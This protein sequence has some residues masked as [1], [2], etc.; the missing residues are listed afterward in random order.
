MN[1]PPRANLFIGYSI[2][3]TGPI[4]TAALNLNYSYQLS[5]KWYST[6]GTS[7]DFGN[8]ILLGSFFSV[9]RIGAD[10]LTS[11]G[12]NL[13][14][15]RNNYTFGLEITPRLSPNIHIGS[16]SAASR[17]DPRYAATQ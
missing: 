16:A 14:P 8:K 9:T 10:F 6:F 12:L 1:R 7:Y 5:P 15:Q 3:N 11:V 2:I 4:N 17:F 13:D